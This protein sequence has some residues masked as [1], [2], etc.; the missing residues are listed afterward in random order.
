MKISDYK[1]KAKEILSAI[2]NATQEEMAE[3]FKRAGQAVTF[4]RDYSPNNV[5]LTLAQIPDAIYTVRE[6][7]WNFRKRRVK[8]ENRPKGA[9]IFSP[10][11]SEKKSCPQGCDVKTAA[12]ITHKTCKGLVTEEFECPNCGGNEGTRRKFKGK[13]WFQCPSCNRKTNRKFVCEKCGEVDFK[14]I[15]FGKGG[16]QCP[17]CQG[18]LEVKKTL[19]G[20]TPITVFDYPQTEGK[21]IPEIE[22]AIERRNQRSEVLYATDSDDPTRAVGCSRLMTD[23]IRSKGYVCEYVPLGCGGY[24]NLS[25]VHVNETLQGGKDLSVLLHEW[26][27]IVL[28]LAPNAHRPTEEELDSRSE[29]LSSS[30]KEIEAEMFSALVLGYLGGFGLTERIF[31]IHHWAAKMPEDQLASAFGRAFNRVF[32]ATFEVIDMLEKAL[33]PEMPAIPTEPK[34]DDF[35]WVKEV[36]VKGSGSTTY[37]NKSRRIFIESVFRSLCHAFKKMDQTEIVIIRD[38]KANEVHVV[39]RDA[40]ET[41]LHRLIFGEVETETVVEPAAEIEIEEPAEIEIEEPTEI[42]IEEPS[43]IEIEEPASEIEV[44][45]LH[46]EDFFGVFGDGDVVSSSAV[47]F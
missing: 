10:I 47:P 29:F 26:A 28:H 2:V 17:A 44:V 33:L 4:M 27:H 21:S 7:A 30:E 38:G 34:D 11:L 22:A 31:Y 18:K 37:P 16:H 8:E 42:E 20:F 14:Q 6:R 24:A 9:I 5:M 32:P 13:W 35:L 36:R 23:F 1:L 45:T 19:V 41:E 40:T 39:K 12:N 25:G 15:N 3:F 46:A 43:E